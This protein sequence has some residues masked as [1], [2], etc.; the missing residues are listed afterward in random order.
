MNRIYWLA[1]YPKS[2]NTWARIFLNNYLHDAD[3]PADINR[4]KGGP[5]AS[6]R[7]IFDRWAGVEAS[8]LAREEIANLRPEVYRQMAQ[9]INHPLYIKVHDACTRNVEGAQL[10]PTDVTGGVLYLVRNPLDVAVSYAHH[11]GRT[12]QQTVETLCNSDGLVYEQRDRIAPQLPQRLLS[13][14]QHVLSW[15]DDSGMRVT[16]VRYED[17]LT[18]P[19]AAFAS[20]LAALDLEYDG[21]RLERAV[22]FSRF[23]IARQQESR[24]GFKERSMRADAPFFR[25]G[26]TGA[27][28]DELDSA[29][30]EQ[31]LRTQAAVMRRFG[32][33]DADDAA[34]F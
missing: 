3:K 2:G 14:S 26:R 10:F 25:E 30:A 33:L 32:Y 31:I 5:I 20:V 21:A 19:S 29:L 1:S 11:G 24:A 18:D 4:L 7:E 17:M 6:D 13:W 12:L 16:V 34:V 15:V 23:E 9:H 28:R 22:S 27:W 8:D